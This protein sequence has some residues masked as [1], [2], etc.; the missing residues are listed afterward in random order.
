MSRE[1]YS[2]HDAIKDKVNEVEKKIISIAEKSELDAIKSAIKDILD[3]LSTMDRFLRCGRY[4]YRGQTFDGDA[5][6]K[7]VIRNFLQDMKDKKTTQEDI[8]KLLT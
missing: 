5:Y 1:Y 2:T 6:E 8:L 3:K 4:S 7:E